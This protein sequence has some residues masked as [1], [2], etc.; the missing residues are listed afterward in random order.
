MRIATAL[1]AVAAALVVAA[2]TASAA[3]IGK[4]HIGKATIAAASKYA[5]I[6]RK[7]DK[8]GLFVSYACHLKVG[9]PIRLSNHDDPDGDTV[10]A[11]KVLAGRYAAYAVTHCPGP[12]GED[13]ISRV[14]VLDVR[15]RRNVHAAK[16]FEG[17]T[18]DF[19]TV[20]MA[21]TP[22]GDVA[23]ISQSD[24]P[25]DQFEVHVM[26]EEGKRT[27]DAAPDIAADS[28][29]IGG[30]RVYWTRGGAPQSALLD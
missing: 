9:D 5:V 14:Y 20:G 10:V 26:T 3:R 17:D 22:H 6:Y 1:A 19:F 25:G 7:K 29:A 16:A 8:R 30:N 24:D 23:W 27:L 28:L 11:P 4:C 21:V 2:P 12:G 13:C 15:T 18:N